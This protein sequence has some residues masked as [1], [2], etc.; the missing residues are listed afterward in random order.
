MTT[1][2]KINAEMNDDALQL[3]IEAVEE[4]NRINEGNWDDWIASEHVVD[5]Y[6][7]ELDAAGREVID[8]AIKSGG[9]TLKVDMPAVELAVKGQNFS[10]SFWDRA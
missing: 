6:E 5:T 9:A 2:Q 4:N 3:A 7:I 1:A 8:R 10:G